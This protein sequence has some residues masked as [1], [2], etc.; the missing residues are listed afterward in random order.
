MQLMGFIFG[1]LRVIITKSLQSQV[2]GDFH[3]QRQ[4]IS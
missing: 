1:V 4:G 3:V 2:K